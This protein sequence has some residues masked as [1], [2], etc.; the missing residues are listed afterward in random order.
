MLWS[1]STDA[2]TSVSRRPPVT[3][4]QACIVNEGLEAALGH[5][6][7]VV[8]QRAHRRRTHRLPRSDRNFL[9]RM[10]WSLLRAWAIAVIA[11][12]A[13]LDLPR[14]RGGMHYEE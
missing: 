9:G 13:A 8:A 1:A 2:L 12:G 10:P 3:P 4:E 7:D 11:G 5:E 6:N 14:N